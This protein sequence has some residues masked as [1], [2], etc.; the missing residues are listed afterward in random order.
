[1]TRKT[2]F[3]KGLSWL[4][5]DNLGLALCTSLKVYANVAKG[6]KLKL[7]KFWGLIPRFAEVTGK[8]LIGVPFCPPLL[9]LNPSWIGLREQAMNM[10]SFK[11]K[12]MGLKIKEQQ[13][14]N[15]NAKNRYN[16]TKD[17]KINLWKIKN[18]VKL[19]NMRT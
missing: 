3:F 11:K 16:C 19:E 1:M 18:I 13:K 15:E 5:F 4:K 9:P 7:R 12:E 6:L 14:S 2:A 8:K 17:F 10:I